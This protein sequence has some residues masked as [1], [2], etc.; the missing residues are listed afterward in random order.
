MQ[1]EIFSEILIFKKA[2]ARKKATKP[3]QKIKTNSDYPS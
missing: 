1:V 2:L 3:S